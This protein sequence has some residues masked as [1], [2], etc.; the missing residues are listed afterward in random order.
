MEEELKYFFLH[1]S[2]FKND[3]Q[4]EIQWIYNKIWRKEIKENSQNHMN[5]KT[6]DYGKTPRNTEV[7]LLSRL[8]GGERRKER[9]YRLKDLNDIPTSWNLWALWHN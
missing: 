9:H 4:Y 5:Q 8:Q 3:L 6:P 7:S 1:F 2:I